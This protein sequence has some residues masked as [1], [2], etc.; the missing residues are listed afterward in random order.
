MLRQLTL[1]L[2]PSSE[3]QRETSAWLI[4]GTTP[5]EWLSS[6]LRITRATKKI[7]LRIMPAEDGGVSG[8]LVTGINDAPA[9]NWLEYGREAENLWIPITAQFLPEVSTSELRTLLRSESI[10]EY[11]WHPSA[12]LI[13]LEASQ[14]LSVAD[15]L[16]VARP[17]RSNWNLAQPGTFVNQRLVSVLPTDSL[18]TELIFEDGRDDIG[19]DADAIDKAPRSP[20]ESSTAGL[21]DLAAKMMSPF[22]R[23][24]NWIANQAPTGATSPTWLNSMNNW[25][26]D[27]LH[28]AMASQSK[29]LN[30]LQRLLSMLDKDPDKGLRYALPFGG[31]SAHR[32]IAPPSNRLGQHGIDYGGFGRGGGA[33]DY[34]DMPPQIAAELLR[35]YREL[36]MREIRLGRF[37]RAAYIYAN[38]LGD[39][40]SAAQVLAD[41]GFH[42]EAAEVYRKKL[43]QPRKAADCLFRAGLWPE[44][45]AIYEELKDWVQVAEIYEKLD[46]K[47]D[48]EIAW[49]NAATD[50]E[51]QR[52][53]IRAAD[54]Y[55]KRLHDHS[56][57]ASVLHHGWQHSATSKDCLTQLFQLFAR[58]ENH[59]STVGLANRLTTDENLPQTRQIDAASVLADLATSYPDADTRSLAFRGSRQIVARGAVSTDSRNRH[60]ALQVLQKLIPDDRLL[61]RDCRRYEQKTAE[62]PRRRGPREISCID[63]ISLRNDVNWQCAERTYGR[64]FAA[65]F[66]EDSLVVAYWMT[67]QHH[68]IEYRQWYV[69]RE[70]QGKIL[71]A[72]SEKGTM[73]LH[74]CGLPTED[75]VRMNLASSGLVKSIPLADQATAAV[76]T[77]QAGLVWTLNIERGVVEI[78]GSQESG[79]PITSRSLNVF[80]TS[81]SPTAFIKP[82]AE[83]RI[84]C[85]VDNSLVVVGPG[86]GNSRQHPDR[87]V[88]DTSSFQDHRANSG[89][90]SEEFLLTHEARHMSSLEDREQPRIA[91]SFREGGIVHWLKSG[92]QQLFGSE[93]FS[94]VTTILPNEDLV[95]TDAHGLIEV[96][97][98]RGE[99][100]QIIAATEGTEHTPVGVLQS[101]IPGRSAAN[102]FYI[103]HR[104]GAVD[105]YEYG[106]QV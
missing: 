33:A 84:A 48:A 100:L 78:Q 61:S 41:G 30:E 8:C 20:D 4:T 35:R 22:A 67:R 82:F 37:R 80:S 94:P 85:V 5:D 34:W 40:Q 90:H 1:K 26:N 105:V 69:R 27:V 45:V 76:G 102:G 99:K 72:P 38:L 16:T 14:I 75:T 77:N 32:G 104:S 59:T 18:T 97:S 50:F 66:T 96:Y 6:I 87:L 58:T 54:V 70:R 64:V 19:T 56:T 12:G 10:Q 49:R 11:V 39:Y 13:G 65:G 53:Y 29:R 31:D 17:A 68:R 25:A 63:R 57:A 89:I 91:L 92:T 62:K 79:V 71:L 28:R 2:R 46:E 60:D 44:A 7:Q 42:R 73:F 23:A 106:S 21:S 52:D 101:Q 93:M 98:T 15:L 36:A 55:E 81:E 88:V 95:V 43:Q 24:A 74:V 51:S 9:N 103:C 83:S 47:E 86:G 3:R